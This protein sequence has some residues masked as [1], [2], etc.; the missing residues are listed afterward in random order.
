M[1]AETCAQCGLDIITKEPSHAQ[2]S[3]LPCAQEQQQ[4]CFHYCHLSVPVKEVKGI[5]VTAKTTVGE[6]AAALVAL[7]RAG[8]SQRMNE[9]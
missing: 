7:P 9:M 1:S 6:S 2:Q 5:E 8:K 3:Y 4:G